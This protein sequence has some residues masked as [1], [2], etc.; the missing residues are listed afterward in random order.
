M[1]PPDDDDFTQGILIAIAI[2]GVVMFVF[3]DAI[4]KLIW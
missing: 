1:T 2:I 4:V 3:S